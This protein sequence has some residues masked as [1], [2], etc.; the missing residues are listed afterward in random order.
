[1]TGEAKVAPRTPKVSQLDTLAQLFQRAEGPELAEAASRLA[2]SLAH[3]L[4]VFISEDQPAKT[5]TINRLA[6]A[7]SVPGP[8]ADGNAGSFGLR[9]RGDDDDH[10]ALFMAA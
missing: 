3:A 2:G 4:G 10:T 6:M 9:A 7:A 8:R 5:I 1:M